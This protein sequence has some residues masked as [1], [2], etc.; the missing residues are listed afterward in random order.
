MAVVVFVF[1]VLM[2]IVFL[3]YNYDVVVYHVSH[4]GIMALTYGGDQFPVL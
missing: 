2:I 4:H 1:L 3:I